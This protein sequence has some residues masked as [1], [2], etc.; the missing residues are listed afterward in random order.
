[1]VNNGIILCWGFYNNSSISLDVRYRTTFA[2]SFSKIYFFNSFAYRQNNDV[3][4]R[5]YF[6]NC[7]QITNST[8]YLGWFRYDGG[9]QY[10]NYLIIGI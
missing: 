1:M 4:G 9:A 5:C 2:I 10:L 6:S 3:N 8:A 7:V